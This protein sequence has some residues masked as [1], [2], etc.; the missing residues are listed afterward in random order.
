MLEAND[1]EDAIVDIINKTSDLYRDLNEVDQITMSLYMVRLLFYRRKHKLIEKVLL[2]TP[3]ISYGEKNIDDRAN[4]NQIKIY[5]AYSLYMKGE[6][7][8]AI[9]K[10]DEFDPLLVQAFMYNHIMMDYKVI[11]DLIAL[12]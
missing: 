10:L 7:A 3:D 12:Q 5:R 8:K 4:I 2:I 9:I 1:Q 11:S 6:K